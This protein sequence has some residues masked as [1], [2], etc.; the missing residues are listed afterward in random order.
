[1]MRRI[2]ALLL[3]VALL[4]SGCSERT[5]ENK[6]PSNSPSPT[7]ADNQPPVTEGQSTSPTPTGS[8]E[9]TSMNDEM[10]S[11]SRMDDPEYMAFVQDMLYAGLEEKFGS[12]DFSV[13]SIKV[14]YLSKEYLDELAYNSQSNIWFGYTLADVKEAFGDVPYVFTLGEDNATV[15]VP[16]Q[17]YDDTYERVIK[18]VAIGAGVIL[19]CATVSVVTGGVGATTIS[20]VFAASAKTGLSMGLSW[21]ALSGLI[22]GTIEGVKTKDLDSAVKAAALAG[23]SSFKWGAI[24]GAVIGGA[25]EVI[26]FRTPADTATAA[27]MAS[28]TPRGAELRALNKYGGEE[29]LSFLNGEQVPF[30]TA[31]ATRPDVVRQVGNHLEAIE[32]KYYNLESSASLNTLRSELTRQVS[33]RMTNLPAGSTQR[34]VL[35]VTGKG[36]TQSFVTSIVEKVSEWLNPIYPNIPIEIAGL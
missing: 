10:V 11:F 4:L 23:S 25:S 33:S 32:V 3:V 8:I 15:V 20:T 12:D 21:G 16:F 7:V 35:D 22:A 34:I 24:A 36:Y 2:V 28:E 6:T 27:E 26:K 13:D 19:V 5:T 18:N 30:G 17:S 14:V 29:Q 9:L 31:G 1:M